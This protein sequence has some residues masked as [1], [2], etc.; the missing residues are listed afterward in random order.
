VG[1]PGLHAAGVIEGVNRSVAARG[2]RPPRR[3]PAGAWLFVALVLLVVGERRLSEI[4]HNLRSAGPG[5]EN[6]D[7]LDGDEI[8]VRLVILNDDKLPSLPETGGV[9]VGRFAPAGTPRLDRVPPGL[10]APRG[11]PSARPSAG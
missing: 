2:P 8:R 10:P 4:H 3:G 1:G 6:A 11:P 7:A 9:P 5:V